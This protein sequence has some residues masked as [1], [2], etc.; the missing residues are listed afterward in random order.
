MRRAGFV[1]L[2]VAGAG[3][4]ALRPAP[5]VPASVRAVPAAPLKPLAAPVVPP[6]ASAVLLASAKQTAPDD[7]L[8]LVAQCLGRGDSLCAAGHLETYVRAH[9]DQPLF[10]YQLA[11]LYA[12][13]DRP[14]EARLHYER[15]VTEAEGP[16]LRPQVVAGHIKLMGMAQQSGDRFGE[17]HHR[18]AGLLLLMREQD[19]ATDRDPIFCEEMTCKALRALT[20]AKELKPNDPRTRVLLAE[21][22]DRVGS[23]QAAAAERAAAR[24]GVTSDGRRVLE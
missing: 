15:F 11:E 13:S 24:A 7:P 19:G 20:D 5:E 14:A 12:R 10:R 3:C 18:G 2:V 4:E 6:S 23:R 22:L 1:L 8:T 9:P 16:T 17:L 21:A